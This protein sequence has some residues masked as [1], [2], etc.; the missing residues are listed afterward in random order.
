M[1][2]ILT[3]KLNNYDFT[4]HEFFSKL[5]IS[6]NVS[7]YALLFHLFSLLSLIIRFMQ[8][9]LYWLIILDIL[10]KKILFQIPHF[11]F[12]VKVNIYDFLAECCFATKLFLV[13][14][15]VKKKRHLGW[16]HDALNLFKANK[17][18]WFIFLALGKL[19]LQLLKDKYSFMFSRTCSYILFWK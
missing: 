7:T 12:I 15:Q 5:V 4:K 2:I 19:L 13:L 1:E 18:S 16:F 3:R 6:A 14:A 8:H 17:S 11:F 9:L 10:F